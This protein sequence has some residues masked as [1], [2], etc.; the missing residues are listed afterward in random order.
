MSKFTTFNCQ[1]LWNTAIFL[2]VKGTIR[3]AAILVKP[4]CKAIKICVACP[5]HLWLMLSN[6]D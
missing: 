2:T 5:H 1:K 6:S 3:T 4:G